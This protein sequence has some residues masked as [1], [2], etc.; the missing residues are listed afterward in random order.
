VLNGKE[1]RNDEKSG[2]RYVWLTRY[3][4]EGSGLGNGSNDT[5]SMKNFPTAFLPMQELEEPPLEG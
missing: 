5:G 3:Q 2:T 1:T 4:V